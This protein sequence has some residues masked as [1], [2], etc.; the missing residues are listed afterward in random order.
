MAEFQDALAAKQVLSARLLRA[1]VAGG[2]LGRSRS[3]LVASAVASASRNVHA[4]GV[5]R[6]IVEGQ[7]TPQPCV[8]L[9]VVQKL[10]E[11]LLSPRDVLPKQV[12]GIITDVIESPPA[13]LQ[14][15]RKTAKPKTDKAKVAASASTT[16]SRKRRERQRPIVGGISAGHHDITAGTLSCFCRS[17]QVG[18]DPAQIFALSNN[19][20]FA[21]VNLGAT[22]D[23]LY[24]PGP[25]DGGTLSDHFAELH[26]FVPIH[27]GGSTPN[28][29]DAA[30]GRLLPGTEFTAEVCS[31]GSITGTSLVEEDMEVRK[32][33]RTSG[34][35]EGFVSNISYDALVGMDHND[36]T[37][38]ALFTN[39]MRIESSPP[40][41]AFGLGGDSG[42]LVF[43]RD[44]NHA[45]GLYFAGPESGTYGIA[46]HIEDVLDRLKIQ[47]V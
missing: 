8:R 30:I 40:Y 42:S 29:V 13:F 21:A 36:S 27:L 12:D 7:T 43:R 28:S 34:Y 44:E 20:V 5:G 35:S 22:G 39:Q 33:G 26:R 25:A 6:K 37:V 19:H 4:I 32:H 18:D 1:G 46:N 41:A 3:L 15:R 45:V 16:C 24:Q 14:A 11:S 38:I 23:D 17:L 10:A 9:Y 31:I 47:L 2:V